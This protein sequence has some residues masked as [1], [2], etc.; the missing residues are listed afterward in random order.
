MLG[1]AALFAGPVLAQKAA[2][3]GWLLQEETR[4]GVNDLVLAWYAPGSGEVLV[5]LNCQERYPDVVFTAYAN[6]PR[7]GTKPPT[8]LALE[9]G[10]QRFAMK[11]TDG[12]MHGRYAVESVTSFQPGLV[13][14]LKEQFTV[15][16]DGVAIGSFS[17]KSARKEFDR[18]IAACPPQTASK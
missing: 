9:N 12:K 7:A 1:L 8:E 18:I 3:E 2:P 10:K 16:V 14:L 15:V 13:D 4:S 5:A 6:P 17:T 11:A